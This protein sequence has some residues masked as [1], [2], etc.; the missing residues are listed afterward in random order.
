M[1]KLGSTVAEPPHTSLISFLSQL[2]HLDHFTTYTTWKATSVVGDTVNDELT[3]LEIDE[4]ELE[5]EDD[6][7]DVAF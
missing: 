1:S 7:Q 5:P 6:I 2:G 3:A 4:S